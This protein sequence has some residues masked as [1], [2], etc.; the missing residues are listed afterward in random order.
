[1]YTFPLAIVAWSL[2]A[3]LYITNYYVSIGG[4]TKTCNRLNIIAQDWRAQSPQVL[5]HAKKAVANQLLRTK[6]ANDGELYIHGCL[7]SLPVQIGAH[8]L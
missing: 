5:W 6:S 3:Y 2:S 7:Y 4:A 1:M 8:E